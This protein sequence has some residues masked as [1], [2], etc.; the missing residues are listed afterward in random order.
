VINQ[1]KID[2]GRLLARDGVPLA[3]TIF[4]EDG[5]AQR[6]YPYPGLS[7]VTGYYSIRHGV[8]GT[9]ATFDP[10][11][12]GNAG[13]S[14][15]E[16]LRDEL[17]HRPLVGQ[18]VTLTIDL[19]AQVAADVA[20]GE[21]EG[22]VVV[23]EIETGAILV[24]SSHPT[25]DP[26]TLDEKWDQLRTDERAPLLNRTAQGLFPVGDL[27]RLI[28]LIGLSEAGA[29][30]PAE[31][32]SAPL[33]EMLGPLGPVGY[34]ATASQLELTRPF[35]Y[36]RSQPGRLPEFEDRKTVRDL[37]I[38]PLHLARLVAALELEGALPEPILSHLVETERI[39]S[40]SPETARQV[41]AWLPQVEE[42]LVGLVG[43]ATPEETGQT[44]LSWFVG[45][46][47]A[48][49]I[50]S[51]VQPSA[52]LTEGELILDPTKISTSTPTPAAVPPKTDPAR[53]VV[54]AVVVTDTP[55]E[56]PALRAARAPLN[57][58]LEG[59]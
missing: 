1:Q 36:I 13:Q 55:V 41:R 30:L 54:V 40:F 46:A 6:H 2:R 49:A 53:Y 3:E 23:M 32:L 50:Q 33:E 4:D 31:P 11:L 8:G 48:T 29:V 47:P 14:R 21:E 42:G 20:L 51:P 57:V 25:Y 22:A 17:L 58:L 28:G 56:N 18:D 24:M 45:L 5:L 27:A 39:Q 35:T 26:N 16:E 12:R 15:E 7:S 34:L 38:T 52:A 59:E 19:P 9:E 37:A 10:L 43:Q 44:S